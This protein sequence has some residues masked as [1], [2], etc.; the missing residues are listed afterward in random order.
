WPPPLASLVP[1]T[2]LFRSGTLRQPARRRIAA[3]H[4]GGRYRH[5]HAVDGRRD[6]LRAVELYD[7]NAG[8]HAG[9]G[10][11]YRLRAVH[12]GPLPRRAAARAQPTG[13]DWFGDRY[14]G[15]GGGFRGPDGDYRAGLAAPGEHHL[16]DIYGLR[17]RGEC[18]HRRAGGPDPA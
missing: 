4:R 6:L 3:A 13:C 16:P 2:T 17:G 14:G 11:R 7:A 1:Y 12:H 8:P 18:L 15:I 10:G 9:P 5:R